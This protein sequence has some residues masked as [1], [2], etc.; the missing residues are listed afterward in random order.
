MSHQKLVL[1]KSERNRRNHPLL[2]RAIMDHPSRASACSNPYAAQAGRLC[3]ILSQPPT[4]DRDRANI[5]HRVGCRA[6]AGQDDSLSRC[7]RLCIICDD[8][9]RAQP[10]KR[11]ADGRQ[12]GAARIHNNKAHFTACLWWTEFQLSCPQYPVQD[13]RHGPHL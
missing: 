6:D 13:A 9:R 12:I 8:R 11:I 2:R 1:R 4:L 7:D 10:F 5:A 3:P